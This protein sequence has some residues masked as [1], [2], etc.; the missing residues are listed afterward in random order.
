MTASKRGDLDN[1]PTRANVH[2]LKASADNSGVAEAL[3]YL[4]RS[5]ICGDVKI[6]G[7]IAEQKITDGSAHHIS[8]VAVCLQSL[9]DLQCAGR[10]I[11]AGETSLF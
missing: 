7:S 11:L 9:D 4:L 6:F 5:G 3:F 1:F 8:L 2:N 10:K